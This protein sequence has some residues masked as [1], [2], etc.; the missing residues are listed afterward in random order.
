ME[1]TKLVDNLAPF[2]E[3]VVKNSL[4]F[5]FRRT[6]KEETPLRAELV[7][8]FDRKFINRPEESINSV[9]HLRPS[10][11]GKVLHRFASK[12]AEEMLLL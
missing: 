5:P 12:R 6:N 10:Q 8:S 11:T 9:F 7:L 4:L 3:E 2:R 1:I